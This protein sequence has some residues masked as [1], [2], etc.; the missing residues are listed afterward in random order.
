VRVLVAGAA[1]FIGRHLSD[2]L[3]RQGHAVIRVDSRRFA[4]DDLPEHPELIGHD[5]RNPLGP[6]PI[7][8]AHVDLVYNLACPAAPEHYQQD[9]V[10]TILTSVEG[11][12]NLIRYAQTAK[13]AF[14]QAS[15]SE[16]YGSQATSMR[17]ES[18]GLVNPVGPRSCYDEGKRC[19]EALIAAYH[20]MS[21][22]RSMVLRLFNVYGPGMA[23][24]DGRM[25]SNFC[26]QVLSDLR[27][28]V[29]GNGSQTR[30]PCYI[31]DMVEA[32]L[33]A[34]RVMTQQPNLPRPWG[35]DVPILNLG[36]D[37]EYTVR[38]IAE[39]VIEL[40]GQGRLE[41]SG[42]PM[43]DPP[44]RKPVLGRAALWLG[45]EP[46]TDLRTGIARMLEDFADRM[47]VLRGSA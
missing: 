20:R 34:G 6:S 1:G 28:T 14:I 30:S 23:L 15:T 11:T 8:E 7:P 39:T 4:I 3:E 38:G 31:D 5:I 17:E 46:T 10:D 9:P 41:Q 29:Y 44:F 16:V 33:A 43:D 21:F 36:N 27:L 37:V 22:Q 32:L 45:W 42:L 2:A 47:G 26:F 24:D 25:L 13:A 19:A 40:A 18:W 35:T 12:K